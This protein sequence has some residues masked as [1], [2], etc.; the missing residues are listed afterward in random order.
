MSVKQVGLPR[1]DHKKSLQSLSYLPVSDPGTTYGANT[2]S[3]MAAAATT[4][5]DGPR[6]KRARLDKGCVFSF[7]SQ[8]K[9]R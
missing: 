9:P 3:T 1:K 4:E 6:R 7:P 5:V 2:V 8:T